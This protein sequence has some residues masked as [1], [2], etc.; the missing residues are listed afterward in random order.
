MQLSTAR[1]MNENIWGL[2]WGWGGAGKACN[3]A[4]ACCHFPKRNVLGPLPVH[5]ACTCRFLKSGRTFKINVW[6]T[7]DDWAW[8]CEALTL[9]F[10]LS[11]NGW[12]IIQSD[13][14]S[15]GL[16]TTEFANDVT[17]EASR[18]TKTR[19]GVAEGGHPSSP[20]GPEGPTG[21]QH[22]IKLYLMEQWWSYVISFVW[23]E[24]GSVHSPGSTK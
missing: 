21:P 17:T 24:L 3:G 5:K 7:F 10:L 16:M 12:C 22:T 19:V 11:E 18:P 9:C 2:G 1:C 23:V 13:D 8:G 14:A 15:W 20:G 6:H 4:R